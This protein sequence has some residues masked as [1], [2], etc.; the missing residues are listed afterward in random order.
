MWNP[1]QE[2]WAK[3]IDAGFF[4]TWPELTAKWVRQNLAPAIETSKGHIRVVRSNIRSTKDIGSEV[5][6]SKKTT[7]LS[8]EFYSKIIDPSGKVCSDQTGKFPVTSS[9]GN[10][11]IMVV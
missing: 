9:K 4:A 1:V 6:I 2:T 3:A 8:S 10:K 5:H 11:H 7:K